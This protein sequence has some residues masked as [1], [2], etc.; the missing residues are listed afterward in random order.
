[1]FCCDTWLLCRL[2]LLQYEAPS[3]RMQFPTRI[4]FRLAGAFFWQKKGDPCP[5][6]RFEKTS[7]YFFRAPAFVNVPLVL[8]TFRTCGRLRN[9]RDNINRSQQ[10]VTVNSSRDIRFCVDAKVRGWLRKIFCCFQWRTWLYLLFYREKDFVQQFQ[11]MLKGN[12][13]QSIYFRQLVVVS[14]SSIRLLAKGRKS[15]ID[16]NF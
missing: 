16:R 4:F 9:V 3:S 12:S 5:F 10:S 14:D 6:F 7:L 13:H 1:M 2:A 15:K 11:T 8:Y